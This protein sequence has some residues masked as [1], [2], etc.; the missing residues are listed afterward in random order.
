MAAAQALGADGPGGDRR[1]GATGPAVSAIGLGLAAVGRPGYITPGRGEDLPDRSERALEQ[2]AR[3]LLDV[4]AA[5]GVRYFDAARS[6][7]RAEAFLGAWIAAG[8]APQDAVIGSKWGYAYTGGWRVDAEIHERKEHSRALLDAQWPETLAALGQAPALYQIHSA[9]LETGVLDNAEVCARLAEIKARGVRIGVSTSGP[10]QAETIDRAL[11]VKIDGRRLFDAVQSTWNL[12]ERSAGPALARAQASGLG[13]I[14]K[15]PVANGRLT[16]RADAVGGAPGALAAICARDGL[17]LDALA[18]AASV[19]QPW[20]SVTL[21]GAVT[22]AQ[23]RSNLAAA[24]I[25]PTVVA[26]ALAA[27]P[28]EDPA[29]YWRLRAQ[30]GWG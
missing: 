2:R 23:L 22:Q 26:E 1:L 29:A 9:T 14:I 17:S 8:G 11:D 7:G 6:Y 25:A 30:L 10:A 15:E 19:A 28:A 18:I 24:E 3:A 27:V 16:P 21:S 5:L 20:V 13:V 12:L 4:A